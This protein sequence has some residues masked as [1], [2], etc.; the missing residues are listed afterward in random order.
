MLAPISSDVCSLSSLRLLQV[1]CLQWHFL[2]EVLW[3]ST[4]LSEPWAPKCKLLGQSEHTKAPAG[5][6]MGS[7][8]G[9]AAGLATDII[10]TPSAPSSLSPAPSPGLVALSRP[11]GP[12]NLTP[13]TFHAA[14]IPVAGVRITQ[15]YRGGRCGPG[16]R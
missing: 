16:D 8:P 15:L 6:G 3:V 7:C 10:N 5:M 2:Q 14:S 13:C 9:S 4:S 11:T 12:N 1:L